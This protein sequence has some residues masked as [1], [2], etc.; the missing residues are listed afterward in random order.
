MPRTTST[1]STLYGARAALKIDLNDNWTITPCIMGQS[2]KANGFNAYDPALGAFNL[3]HFSPDSVQDNFIDTALT[4]Q[5]KISN[6]DLIYTGAY[7]KRHDLT[8]TDYSDYS[9]AYDI[10]IPSYTAPIVNDQ[11]AIT[12]IRRR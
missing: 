3:E 5:G 6:F 8:H 10:S 11:P 12:S 4:V 1:A 9:L 2:T 7:L